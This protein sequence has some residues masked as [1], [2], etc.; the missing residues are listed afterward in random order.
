VAAAAIY[1]EPAAAYHDVVA[2][3]QVLHA[4]TP[5]WD[6]CTGRGTPDITAFVA[7]A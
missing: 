3:S 1:R 7:G 6:Y 5:G 2:G 4:A